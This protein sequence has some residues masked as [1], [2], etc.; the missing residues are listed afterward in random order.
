MMTDMLETAVNEGT[1]RGAA[2][3]NAIVAGKTGTTNSNYDSWFCGYSAYYTVAVWQGYDYPASIPQ[4]HT[5]DIFRQFMQDSHKALAK[6]DFPKYRQ[7]SDNKET[8]TESVSE[9]QTETQS[10]SETQSVTQTQKGSQIQSSSQ[11]ETGTARDNDATAGT[12]QD[13]TAGGSESRADTD[14]PAETKGDISGY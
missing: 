9:T 2:P 8:E 12:R 7:K 10:V 5:K 6:K 3:D 11:M 4:S 13:S 14:K 1:G